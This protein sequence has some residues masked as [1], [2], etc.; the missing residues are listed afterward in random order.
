MSARIT[1]SRL[2]SVLRFCE[3]IN[4]V[5]ILNYFSNTMNCR[6]E[7]IVACAMICRVEDGSIQAIE[8]LTCD[9]KYTVRMEQCVV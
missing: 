6:S 2:P 3:Q 5:S 8:A 9:C 7:Y 1:A 4:I